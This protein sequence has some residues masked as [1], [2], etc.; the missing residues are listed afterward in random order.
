MISYND[1]REMPLQHITANNVFGLD[2][3]LLSVTLNKTAC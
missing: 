2:S 3:I 1:L